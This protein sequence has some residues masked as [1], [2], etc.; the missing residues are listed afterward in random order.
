MHKA[1]VSKLLA[2]KNPKIRGH[3]LTK[4]MSDSTFFRKRV[5]L[6]PVEKRGL[7]SYAQIVEGLEKIAAEGTIEEKRAAKTELQKWAI[8]IG[9]TIEEQ[10]NT[11]KKGLREN[12]TKQINQIIFAQIER[13]RKS[14]S[15]RREIIKLL[16]QKRD[17]ALTESRNAASQTRKEIFMADFG[18]YSKAI[19]QVESLK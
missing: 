3:N 14:P 17:T 19:E 13:A 12:H 5:L 11:R 4:L 15:K 2:H 1:L 18:A 16:K 8:I 10:V 9:P 7:T 6:L